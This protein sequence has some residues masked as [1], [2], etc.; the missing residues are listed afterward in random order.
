M[1]DAPELAP[2]ANEDPT[3]RKS[4][5]AAAFDQAES[6]PPSDAA[7]AEAAPVRDEKG[8]FAPKDPAEA[9]PAQAA[10]VAEEPPLWARAPNS[11]KKD[12]HEPWQAVD[13]KIREYIWT[14][15][16]EMAAGVEPLKSKAQV[17]DAFEQAI[18]PYKPILQGLGVEPIQAIQGLMQNDYILRYGTPQQKQAKVVE[19]I[20]AYGIDVG[21]IDQ[22]QIRP[23]DPAYQ[24]LQQQLLETRSMIVAQQQAAQQSE[25]GEMLRAI[26]AAAPRLEHFDRVRPAMIEIL[27]AGLVPEGSFTEMTNAAYEKAIRLDDDLWNEV[28]QGRQAQQA[29]T[30][31]QAADQ[32]AKS[33][34]RAAVSPPSSTPGAPSVPKAQDRRTLLEEQFGEL[35]T[36]L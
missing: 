35:G 17:A 6:A 15:E 27:N 18:T 9:A 20:N 10:P 36:R 4:L 8:R 5:L 28:Q 16:Q 14:R 30:Q 13:P 2:Q 25:E 29:E 32:A 7:P 11:W 1:S 22:S 26:N 23:V 33:A 34:R 31:R 3:D 21:G 12:Y 24:A 19:L